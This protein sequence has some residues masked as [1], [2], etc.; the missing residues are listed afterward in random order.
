MLFS[1]AQQ[2]IIA[3]A[4]SFFVDACP[5][6]GKTQTIVQRFIERPNV[7]NRSGVALLSF[8]NAAINEVRARCVGRPELLQVPN[9]VGTID[10][11]INRFIVGPLYRREYGRWPSFKD[12]WSNLQGTT[13]TIEWIPRV[14][15]RLEWFSFDTDGSALYEPSRVP[16]DQSYAVAKLNPPQIR[17]ATIRAAQIQSQFASNGVIDA[18]WSR[19]LM[20]KYLD[21]VQIGGQ[22]S[23]LLGWRFAEAIIDEVQD[24]SDDDLRLI[25]FLIDSGINVVMVGD[26]EQAIYA[27]RGS[28]LDKIRTLTQ[29]V[30]AKERLNHNYR[31][32]PNICGLVNSLR[33]SDDVD[34]PMGVHKDYGEPIHLVPIT[35]FKQGRQPAIQIA[36]GCG[37]AISD[38]TVLA[39]VASHARACAGGMSDPSASTD[40]IV[41]LA[42]AASKVQDRQSSRRMREQGQQEFQ[43][44][45]RG[46]ADQ[47]LH[48]LSDEDFYK[49]VGLN[50]QLLKDGCVRLIHRVPPFSRR[51]SAFKDEIK[52]GIVALG[53]NSWVDLRPLRTPAG[54]QWKDKLADQQGQLRWSTIHQFKGLQS[55]AV[56]LVIP[57]QSERRICGVKCWQESIPEEARRILYVGASRAEQLLIL[58]VHKSQV[59]IVFECLDRDGVTYIRH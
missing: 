15:F 25:E 11:F 57:A 47:R 5:G 24:C 22:I 37:I 14:T 36:E 10:S 8:T 39:H 51:P 52:A 49:Q 26:L 3:A 18:D 35:S 55:P 17:A 40:R 53:W 50:E 29:K 16:A 31:S 4:G 59:D 13:F 12:T 20:W 41:L 33:H 46:L 56:A 58:L 27:F 48:Y 1:P 19:Q 21:D 23:N 54:D 2:A 38:V 32:A 28:S 6:A 34:L 44:L 30:P 45:L 43:A 9:F 42:R 7:V